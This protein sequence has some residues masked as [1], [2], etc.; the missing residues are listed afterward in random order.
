[1]KLEGRWIEHVGFEAGQRVKVNV[2][3]GQLTI[4]PE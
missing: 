4:T 3:H 1:M 2:E